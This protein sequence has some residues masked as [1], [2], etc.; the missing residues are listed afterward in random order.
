[1]IAG[2]GLLL[3]SCLAQPTG[4]VKSKSYDRT[5]ANM[6]DPNEVSIIGVDSLYRVGTENVILLDTRSREEYDVSHIPGALWVGYD[7]F[8]PSRIRELDKEKEVIV[9]CSVGYRSE[10]IGS[11]L[12]DLGF[13]HVQ[14][15]YG[16]IFEWANASYPLVRSAGDTVNQIHPY[17]RVWGRWM[18]NPEVEKKY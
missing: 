11:Q 13:E 9:Y 15:L 10:K 14:N 16:S 5:L 4:L 7:S 12:K 17:N 8:D 3:P 1:M 18:T 6:L 2:L